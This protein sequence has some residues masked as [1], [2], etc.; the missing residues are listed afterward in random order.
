MKTITA[1]AMVVIGL[2]GLSFIATAQPAPFPS[3]TVPFTSD[4]GRFRGAIGPEAED[5]TASR[6]VVRI[7]GALWLRLRIGDH[8]LGAES[9]ITVTSLK[10]GEQ[11]RLDA[12][13]LRLWQNQ[14]AMFNGDVVEVELHVAPG[15]EGIFFRIE[16]VTA[17][18]AVSGRRTEGGVETADEGPAAEAICGGADDRVPSTHRAAGRTDG[19]CTAWI[20][21][22]GAYLTAGHCTAGSTPPVQLAQVHFNIPQSQADG[23]IV[24]PPLADQY[25]VVADSIVFADDGPGEVGQDWAVFN[26]GPNAG[27]NRLAVDAQG[28]FFRMSRDNN[29]ATVRITGHGA[30]GPAPNFGDPPPGNAD[31]QTQQT[32]TGQRQG[33]D[34]IGTGADVRWEYRVDT[35]GGNPAAP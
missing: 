17:G 33:A 28:A 29:P 34:D 31:N 22:N 18:E 1:A 7:P 11:Q 3:R 32:H 12:K 25:P 5:F 19:G 10:D 27:N 35:Q 2:S 30:D 20:A 16:E 8:N 24:A 26:L 21:S 15:E 13:G 6:Q 4:I 14:T 9:Y 23:T